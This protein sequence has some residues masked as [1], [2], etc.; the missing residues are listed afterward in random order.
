MVPMK[1]TLTHSFEQKKFLKFELQTVS[2]SST[3]SGADLMATYDAKR[4]SYDIL[5]SV[6]I[7]QERIKE[8]YYYCNINF[9][10]LNGAK[11]VR[12]HKC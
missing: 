10:V 6:R 8:I 11:N 5:F 9:T 12:N 3:S 1:S 4:I 7:F 2:K